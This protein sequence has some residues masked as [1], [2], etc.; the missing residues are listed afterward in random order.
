[1]RVLSYILFAMAAFVFGCAILVYGYV[2]SMACGY[3][4][5]SAACH[6]APADLASDDRF[7]LVGLPGGIVSVLVVLALL[8]RRQANRGK[9]PC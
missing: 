2:T 3:A 9:K 5:S 6:A 8:A 4:P 1:M 7:W